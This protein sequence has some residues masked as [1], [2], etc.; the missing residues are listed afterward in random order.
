[1]LVIYIYMR[2][3]YKKRIYIYIY[4]PHIFASDT[5]LDKKKWYIEI[6]K[7]RK[8][9]KIQASRDGATM[10]QGWAGEHP[11]HNGL[12]SSGKVKA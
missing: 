9:G 12:G 7:I 2:L 5:L 10:Y 6:K 11:W 8:F 1:M 4:T 3:D